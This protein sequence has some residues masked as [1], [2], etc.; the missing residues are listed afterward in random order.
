M[1]DHTSSANHSHTGQLYLLRLPPELGRVA[2]QHALAADNHSPRTALLPSKQIDM[3]VKPLP[4]SPSLTFL[5]QARLF[6]WLES[7][8]PSTLKQVKAI[9]LGL[10]DISLDSVFDY[11]DETDLAA[12]SVS[13]M[14]AAELTRLGSAFEQIPSLTS[15]TLLAPTTPHCFLFMDLYHHFVSM[16]SNRFVNI[17]A[18]NLPNLHTTD[19]GTRL[20][21]RVPHDKAETPTK[22]EDV[23][24]TFQPSEAL[25]TL[26]QKSYQ[27]S[28]LI[29]PCMAVKCKSEP[30]D[31]GK[32]SRFRTPGFRYDPRKQCITLAIRSVKSL[33]LNC[34]MS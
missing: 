30:T 7:S 21:P 26:A 16:I 17:T 19:V 2:Y 5:S 20:R 31:V 18:L 11:Q 12:L 22:N 1:I 15:L 34:L 14:Y 24:M 8:D 10:S 27:E 6:I 23:T 13:Q 32:G 3:D 29:R 4:H 25:G 33:D 28:F 9:T